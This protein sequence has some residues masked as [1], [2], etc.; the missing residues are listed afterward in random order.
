MDSPF[1]IFV[2]AF[3]HNRYGR[4]KLIMGK[5]KFAKYIPADKS[6]KRV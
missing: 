4:A 6:T 2:C 3:Y 5:I 1:F